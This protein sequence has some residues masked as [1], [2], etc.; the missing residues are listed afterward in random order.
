MYFII[1]ILVIKTPTVSLKLIKQRID[2]SEDTKITPAVRNF[3][4]FYKLTYQL[5][6]GNKSL[7][8][9]GGYDFQLT[10][11]DFVDLVTGKYIKNIL[12]DSKTLE[13]KRH[14]IEEYC[15][16]FFFNKNLVI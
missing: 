12:F 4:A 2:N 10:E 9:E 15:K 16:V 3:I 7:E 6:K 11:K 8:T 1:N 14:Y 13:K 5:K